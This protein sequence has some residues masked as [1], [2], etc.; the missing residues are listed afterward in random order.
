[1]GSVLIMQEGKASLEQGPESSKYA[2]AM[3]PASKSTVQDSF[4]GMWNPVPVVRGSA[5]GREASGTEKLCKPSCWDPG[6]R[7]S[8]METDRSG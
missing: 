5:K 4:W 8:L 3:H 1:M 6:C 7:A 2:S